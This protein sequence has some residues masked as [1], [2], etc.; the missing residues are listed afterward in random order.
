MTIIEQYSYN[1]SI[2]KAKKLNFWIVMVQWAF[3][4]SIVVYA[5]T[6]S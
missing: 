4:L 1:P 2:L 3:I 5:G 6:K